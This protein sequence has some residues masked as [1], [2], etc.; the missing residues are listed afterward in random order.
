MIKFRPRKINIEPENDGL[1]QMIFLF[2]GF[3]LRF[4]VNLPGFS[5]YFVHFL[6]AFQ[7]VDKS[8]RDESVSDNGCVSW[9]IYFL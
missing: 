7:D 1:V 2:Q 9:M 6:G 4:H 5:A 3:I 8:H